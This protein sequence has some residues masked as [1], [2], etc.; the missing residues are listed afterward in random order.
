MSSVRRLALAKLWVPIVA[1]ALISLTAITIAFLNVPIY[2]F[3]LLDASAPVSAAQ[4]A[5]GRSYQ[6]ADK[7]VRWDP[8]EA[9]QTPAGQ[10]PT[11][12]AALNQN[13]EFDPPADKGVTS[14]LEDP[15]SAVQQ[16]VFKS[17]RA[18]ETVDAREFLRQ[19]RIPK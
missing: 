8:A 1:V 3:K 15:R 17:R 10:T 12:T 7:Q 18:L 6:G 5:E 11:E 14:I 4:V 16:R 19:S 2:L 13:P 9:E